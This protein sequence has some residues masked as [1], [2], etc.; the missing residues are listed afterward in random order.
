[1]KALTVDARGFSYKRLADILF[2]KGFRQAPLQHIGRT[3]P[4]GCSY[5]V[6]CRALARGQGKT[7]GLHE[8]RIAVPPKAAGYWRSHTLEPLALLAQD[9]IEQA[10]K[11]RGALR[12]ALM[13]L[14]QNGPE[15]TNFKQRHNT[16]EDRARP[17]LE[18]LEAEIDRDF[19]ERLFEEIEIGSD[20]DENLAAQRSIRTSWLTN[21][22]EHA[23]AILKTAE[24]GSPAS[25]VR[26]YRAWVR[27]EQAFER[28][29]L[30]AFRN[31][32]FQ[33]DENN[34]AA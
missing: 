3:D 20:T 23:K 18:M 34:A 17:Y 24:A 21:L 15:R 22:H 16:S 32:Y 25:A 13:M 12:Y 19:F 1:M 27:A 7:E 6:I 29:F 4:Q 11:M 33:R 9:R 5:L 10:G 14:F 8:R 28:A 31:P 30:A 26:H 2:E